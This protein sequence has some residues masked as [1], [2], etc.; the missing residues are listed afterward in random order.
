[1]DMYVCV[2]GN[3]SSVH[4]SWWRV[5]FDCC[6]RVGVCLGCQDSR[7][8]KKRACLQ[9][10]L[11]EPVGSGGHL[12][13]WGGRIWMNFKGNIQPV[14]QC[15]YPYCVYSYRGQDLASKPVCRWGKWLIPDLRGALALTRP[16]CN[17][18][19]TSSHEFELTSRGF[20]R[21]PI[22]RHTHL[23]P[24]IVARYDYSSPLLQTGC[25][26]HVS[27][28]V[29]QLLCEGVSEMGLALLVNCIHFAHISP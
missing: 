4:A 3:N 6:A 13:F 8:R 12:C 22:G 26:K 29:P 9:P 11:A 23:V 7:Q 27:S 1:M 2:A 24:V 28:L 17:V 5:S 18:C 25:W 10:S 19:E 21:R 16:H 15:V 14:Q 20:Y